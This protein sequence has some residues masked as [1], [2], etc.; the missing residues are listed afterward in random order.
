MNAAIAS[1]H[2]E[3]ILDAAKDL[4][5]LAQAGKWRRFKKEIED[6]YSKRVQAKVSQLS[7]IPGALTQKTVSEYE[8]IHDG[9]AKTFRGH[10]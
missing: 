10:D 9:I 1:C 7:Q 4:E 2:G 8:L 6:V 3:S 5:D